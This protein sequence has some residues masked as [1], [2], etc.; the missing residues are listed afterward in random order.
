M[1]VETY[2][3]VTIAVKHS[4]VDAV[5]NYIIDNIS[6]GLLLEDEEGNSHTVIKFYVSANTPLDEKVS[7]LTAYLVN[8][9][10]EYDEVTVKSKSIKNIDWLE[11]YQKSVIPIEIGNSIVITPPWNKDEFTDKQVIIIEPKMAFG[12]GKHETTRSCLAVLEKLELSGKT[13]FDLGCGSGILGIYAAQMG[14]I[15]VVGYDTD[16]LAVDNSIENFEINNVADICEAHLGN[17][18]DVPDE[19]TYEIVIVNIIKKVIVP[20]MAKLK[21]RVSPGGIIILSGLLKQDGPDIKKAAAECGMTDFSIHYDND[22]ITYT[23]RV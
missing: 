1:D 9:D 21:A 19:T 23:I 17:I 10:D 2:H 4:D 18:D 6:T 16:E 20:I 3:E 11:S 22:W 13:I 12:T 15:K 8:V 5:S 7:A 14:A